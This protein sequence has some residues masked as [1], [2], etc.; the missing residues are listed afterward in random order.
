M[1]SK[2]ERYREII[3][4]ILLGSFIFAWAVIQP[5]NVSPDEHMRY[6]ICEYIYEHHTLPHG[7][8][9]AIRDAVWGYSYAFL[10]ILPQ[11][12]GAV[13]MAVVSWFSRNS[14]ALLMAARMVSVLCGIGMAWLCLRIGGRLWKKPRYKWLFTILATLLPQSLFLFSYLNNDSMALFATAL[15]FYAWVRGRDTNWSYGSCIILAI[16]IIV[17][18]LSYYNAYGVIL[19]S[20]MLF[21]GTLLLRW[22]EKEERK[23]LLKKGLFIA[24]LVLIGIGW[25][26]FRNYML[27]NGD[28]LGISTGEAYSQK[29]AIDSIKPA[30]RKTPLNMGESLWTMLFSDGWLSVTIMSFIGYFG[31]MSIPLNKWMYLAYAL[32]L[33]AG[34]IA[35]VFQAFRHRKAE[36]EQKLFVA[37]ML[38][39]AILPNMLNIIHSYYVDYEPQGR[40]SMPMLLPFLYF[41][42]SGWVLLVGEK[43]DAG[44]SA[45]SLSAEERTAAGNPEKISTGRNWKILLIPAIILVWTA[46]ALSVYIFIYYPQTHI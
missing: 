23:A 39:T 12:L 22:K 40:Y 10:P 13:F 36:G 2:R 6:A 29:Y 44:T 9:P 34:L 41:V 20:I 27:Y 1:S 18:A 16:G 14:F 7:G 32:I 11:I 33:G 24:A 28:F 37:A 15:I 30:G 42:T 17:C 5:F 31:Y 26:F 25:W 19:S 45:T 8:D 3:F 46:L 21:I 38:L 35:A 43:L 4:L